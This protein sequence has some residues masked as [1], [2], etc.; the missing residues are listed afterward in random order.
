[1]RRA[2]LVALV[3]ALVIIAVALT[4]CGAQSIPAAMSAVT[5][6]LGG[7]GSHPLFGSWTMKIF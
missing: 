7:Y 4:V 3:L 6:A 1:V 5:T 2:A